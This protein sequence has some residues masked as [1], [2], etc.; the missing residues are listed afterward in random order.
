MGSR[1]I[2]TFA[3]DTIEQDIRDNPE[4]FIQD[5]IHVIR[6]PSNAKRSPYVEHAITMY[7]EKTYNFIIGP[8]GIKT[9]WEN[10][11]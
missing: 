5:L 6:N 9:D 1:C 2:I 10:V 7:H 8:R 3:T 11:G 4:A